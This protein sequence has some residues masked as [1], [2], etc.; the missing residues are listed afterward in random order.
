[1]YIYVR[2]IPEW[3]IQVLILVHERISFDIW[4]ELTDFSLLKDHIIL[5][6]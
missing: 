2:N 1:M 3:L 5:E 4:K 6:N